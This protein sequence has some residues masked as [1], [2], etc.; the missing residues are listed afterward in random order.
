ML[1]VCDGALQGVVV[2]NEEMC[3][4]VLSEGVLREGEAGELL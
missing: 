1:V 4:E 2:E 3:E